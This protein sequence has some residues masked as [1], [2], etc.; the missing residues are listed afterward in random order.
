MASVDSQS[1]RTVHIKILPDHDRKKDDPVEWL[2]ISMRSL[3]G[4]QNTPLM[5]ELKK[6]VEAL[7]KSNFESYHDNV[8]PAISTIHDRWTK[9]YDQPNNSDTLIRSLLEF[10]MILMQIA[11]DVGYKL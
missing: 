9:V 11:T 5:H 3:M 1:D 6:S 2:Q 7:A 8:H 4:L 10:H